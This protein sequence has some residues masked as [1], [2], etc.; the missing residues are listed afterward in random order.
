MKVDCEFLEASA[1]APGFLKPAD[2]LFDDTAAAICRSVKGSFIAS[3]VFMFPMCDDRRN[4][5]GEQPSSDAINAVGFVARQTTGTTTRRTQWL[6][7]AD[8]IE[9]RLGAGGF[10]LLA[11]SDSCDQRSA[12]AVSNQMEFGSETASAAAQRVIGG[13]LGVMSDTFL[14]APAAAREARICVPSMHHKSH[15]SLP[16]RSRRICSVF[17][18]RSKVPLRRHFEKWSY[19]VCQGPKRSGKSRQ[20]APVRRI[21]TMPFHIFRGSLA[22]RPVRAAALGNKGPTKRHCSSVISCRF[23]LRGTPNLVW[24]CFGNIT[25]KNEFSDRT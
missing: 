23:I 3:G 19:T 18:I 1:N 8:G 4:L 7:N 17:R 25:T 10:V 6:S 24:S 12:L 20:G 9:Q 13:F 5:A 21:Q 22:G 2:A 16:S 11:G 14:L 15:S